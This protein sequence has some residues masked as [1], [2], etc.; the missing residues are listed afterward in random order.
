MP[1]KTTVV[2]PTNLGESN[3]GYSTTPYLLHGW[4]AAAGTAFPFFEYLHMF[5]LDS[6]IYTM[7]M[8]ILIQ[9]YTG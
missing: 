5:L 3:F 1:E 2:E 6:V 4:D 8:I 9:I 7:M